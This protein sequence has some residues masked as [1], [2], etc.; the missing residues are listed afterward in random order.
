[1]VER[2]VGVRAVKR[3]M[4]LRAVTQFS[5]GSLLHT[6]PI[7]VPPRL[8]VDRE[9]YSRGNSRSGWKPSVPSAS[10]NSRSDLARGRVSGNDLVEALDMPREPDP[11]GRAALGSLSRDGVD[12]T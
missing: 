7:W 10:P 1:M 12:E 4:S 11:R 2:A 6:V 8:R 9:G 3:A 5:G